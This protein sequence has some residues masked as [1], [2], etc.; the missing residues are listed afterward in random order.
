ML[1][2]RGIGV[3][4]VVDIDEESQ[5]FVVSCEHA[6]A[7]EIFIEV[8]REASQRSGIQWPGGLDIEAGP[9]YPAEQPQGCEHDPF[10]RN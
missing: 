10:S 9:L 6:V 2:E 4:L 7:P 5:G 8:L 1:R 3:K